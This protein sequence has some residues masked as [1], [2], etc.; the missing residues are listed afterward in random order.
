[1]EEVEV[2]AQ[3]MRMEPARQAVEAVPVMGDA[4]ALVAGI[5][6][7]IRTYAHDILKVNH[8]KDFRSH[9]V[10]PVKDLEDCCLVVIRAGYKGDIVVETVMGTMWHAGGWVLWTLIWKGH[11]VLLEPPPDLD[12]AFF[13]ARWQPHNTPA[14]GFLF[15]WHSRHD[16][17]RTAPGTICCRLCCQGRKAGDKALDQNA[18]RKD[19]SLAAAAIVGFGA[20]QMAQIRVREKKLCLQ[21]VFAGAGALSKAW[22]SSWHNQ[23]HQHQQQQQQQGEQ[24]N[25]SSAALHIEVVPRL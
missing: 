17:E 8:N 15:L 25:S 23:Q 21:E 22:G 9:A 7:E 3:R 19:R 6:A 13:M 10:F 11:M 20:S 24:E 18:L 1:M 16:Q 2:E 12:V 14:L 4:R 5:E